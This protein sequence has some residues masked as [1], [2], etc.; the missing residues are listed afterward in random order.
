MT[1][2]AAAEFVAE[3]QRAWSANA[4]EVH[5]LLWAEQI[6]LH[7]PLL[8][9]LYGR[10]QCERAFGKL[11]ELSPDLTVEVTGW[12]GDPDSLFVAFVFSMTFGGA[13]LR[14]PAVDRFRLDEHG[15]I[16]RRD[17]FFDPSPV[18]AHVL[19]HPRGWPRALRAKLVPRRPDPPPW[20]AG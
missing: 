6:E 5:P 7:Q 18:L 2:D 8:G 14:W 16:R 1:H 19:R 4:L 9:S 15:M 13:E 11:F 17:S 3:F 12:S 20:P 10:A